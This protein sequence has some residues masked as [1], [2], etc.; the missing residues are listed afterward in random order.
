[1]A[2]LQKS[3]YLLQNLLI[4]QKMCN[5]IAQITKSYIFWKFKYAKKIAKFFK[6]KCVFKEKMRKFTLKAFMQKSVQNFFA[7]I[8]QSACFC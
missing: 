2:N 3:K 4:K 6:S 7:K 1:M 8:V 5:K